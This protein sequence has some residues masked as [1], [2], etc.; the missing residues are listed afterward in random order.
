M[1]VCTL[2]LFQFD[3]NTVAVLR[4]EEHNWLAMSTDLYKHTWVCWHK[5]IRITMIKVLT[6]GSSVNGR[7]WSLSSLIACLISLTFE[8]Q[9]TFQCALHKHFAVNHLNTDMV[10]S[11]FWFLLQ[12]SFYWTVFTKWME[13][14]ACTQEWSSIYR[15][16]VRQKYHY[17]HSAINLQFGIPEVNKYSVDPVFW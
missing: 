7:T 13:Q 12:K 5:N 10:Y 8:G 6:F 15:L 9:L 16:V 4:M 1:C 11:S 3:E 17:L 14:L 2:F